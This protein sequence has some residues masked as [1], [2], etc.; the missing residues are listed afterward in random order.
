MKPLRISLL[1]VAPVPG[2]LAYNRQLLEKAVRL[3]AEKGADWAVS[4][5]LAVSG[6]QFSRSV[7]TDWIAP[8]PDRWMAEFCQTVKYLQITVFL[9]GPERDEQTDKLYNSVFV[10]NSHGEILGKHRKVN[11]RPDPWASPGESVSLIEWQTLK[12]GVLICSDAYTA[13]V[14]DTLKAQ[15]AQILVSPAAWGPGLHGPKGEWEQRTRETGLPLI[16]C[17][18][19]G[20][21]ETISFLQAESLIIKEGKRLLAFRSPR[22]VVLTFDWDVDTMRPLSSDYQRDY[23]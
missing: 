6:Y 7:G 15:G 8:Q 5:E 10:I 13:Y 2:D 16:V 11:T 14:T 12:V 17:N 23:L 9:A 1:H 3:A 20:E 4:P 18:R 22:S 19:T 21:E